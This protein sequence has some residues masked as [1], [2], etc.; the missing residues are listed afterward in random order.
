MLCIIVIPEEGETGNNK[1]IIEQVKN[2]KSTVP[3]SYTQR[4]YDN[5][6]MELDRRI[7]FDDIE[8]YNAVDKQVA[9]KEF[10]AY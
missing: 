10:S 8:W 2:I 4:D 9:K 3:K 6:V 1:F 7:S 5:A